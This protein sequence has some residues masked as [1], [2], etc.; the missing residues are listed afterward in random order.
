MDAGCTNVNR[1]IRFI[2]HRKHP[3]SESK[4]PSFGENIK[5]V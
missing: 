3:I 2:L 1:V 4:I 5:V